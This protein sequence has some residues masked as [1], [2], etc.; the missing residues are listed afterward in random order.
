MASLAK[1]T[2]A[3]PR[4]G[5]LTVQSGNLMMNQIENG[6]SWWLEALGWLME[7]KFVST[8]LGIAFLLLMEEYA[9]SWY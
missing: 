2:Q 5:S 4:V 6:T 7:S 9:D 1:L 3:M 8:D